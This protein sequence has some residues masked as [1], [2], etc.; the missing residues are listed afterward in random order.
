[1]RIQDIGTI[2]ALLHAAMFTEGALRRRESLLDGN[3]EED[4]QARRRVQQQRAR[5]PS[6]L[7]PL[8]MEPGDLNFRFSKIPVL[9]GNVGALFPL[10]NQHYPMRG[11]LAKELKY[12]TTAESVMTSDDFEL[13]SIDEAHYMAKVGGAPTYPNQDKNHPFWR[14]FRAVMEAQIHRRAN[15]TLSDVMTPPT[16][17]ENF[18]TQ[19]AADAVHGEYPGSV[20]ALMINYFIKIGIK[21][22]NNII[23]FRGHNDFIGRNF[24]AARINTWA[25]SQVGPTNFRT[26]WTYGR[27]RPEEVRHICKIVLWIIILLFGSFAASAGR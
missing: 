25:T 24:R 26:K 22:D 10:N 14:D 4:M 19:D 7:L 5:K 16:L 3:E 2:L 8:Q 6:Y 17:W 12:N 13:R 18:T 1:M 27:P 21:I 9:R 15:G 20:Q 11:S 23:P